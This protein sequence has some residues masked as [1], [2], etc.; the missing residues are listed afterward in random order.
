MNRIASTITF[1]AASATAL[2]LFAA[3]SLTAAPQPE[4]RL[5][6]VTARK[7]EYEPS[8][9]TLQKGVP[10]DIELTSLDRDHGFKIPALGIRADIK[11]G[12]TT[13]V[14]LVPEQV[15]RFPFAC[16]VFC[17]DGHED[18]GGEIVV[19]E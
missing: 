7:F 10:V 13:R 8:T 6:H 16:D 19:V 15:G 3:P 11:P 17:G 2:A 1:A 18:M 4:A 5:V 14:H 9:I 12:A